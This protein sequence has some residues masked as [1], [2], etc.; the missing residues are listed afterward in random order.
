MYLIEFPQPVDG[1]THGQRVTEVRRNDGYHVDLLLGTVVDGEF[2]PSEG[3]FVKSLHVGGEAM[4]DF[5]EEVKK[6]PE[7]PADKPDYEYQA[8]DIA[9]YHGTDL[10]V[11]AAR[12]AARREAKEEALREAAEA[13]AEEEVVA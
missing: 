1:F 13:L 7:R 4:E 6:A 3:R 12:I 11:R 5:V 8:S 9:A 2:V 10:A